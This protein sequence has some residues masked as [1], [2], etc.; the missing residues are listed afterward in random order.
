MEDIENKLAMYKTVIKLI[1]TYGTVLW[2]NSGKEPAPRRWAR[3]TA[4]NGT[5]RKSCRWLVVT[6]GTKIERKGCKNTNCPRGN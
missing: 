2:G 4:I 1:W 6:S 3:I 5:R